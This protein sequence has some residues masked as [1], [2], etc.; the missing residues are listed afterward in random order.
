MFNGRCAGIHI[1]QTCGS[2]RTQTR[3]SHSGKDFSFKRLLKGLTKPNK[4]KK[5]CDSALMME[6]CLLNS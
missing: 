5:A 1:G 3:G 6:I 4:N 2:W